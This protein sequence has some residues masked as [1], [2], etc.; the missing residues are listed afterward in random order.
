MK[1]L[2]RYIVRKYIMA[3]DI[4]EALRKERMQCQK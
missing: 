2:K 4:N 3:K 1:K